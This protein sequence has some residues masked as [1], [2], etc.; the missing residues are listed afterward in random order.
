MSEFKRARGA[1]EKEQRRAAILN[2]A[3]MLFSE[4]Q[5]SLP[6][7][8]QI[9]KQA[10]IAKGTLY[11]Y[12]RSKEEIFLA[13]LEDYHRQ[14]LLNLEQ[15]IENNNDSIQDIVEHSCQYLEQ[16]PLFFRLA[17]L[18]SSIIEQNIDTNILIANK[19]EMAQQLK[20]AAKAISRHF[21]H[22]DNEQGANLIMHSYACLIGLW[23]VSHPSDAIAK[24][25]ESPSLKTLKP[26][27]SLSARQTMLTLWQSTLEQ[28]KS[29]KSG[30]WKKLFS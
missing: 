3:E 21:T 30:I 24:V 22:V 28:K 8:A 27:F 13:L 18:S 19:N 15:G 26:E 5:S 6:T 14:W 23:Q 1:K 16:H 11:L 20:S 17:S 12:F 7:T 25:L 2:A 10:G 29:E 9:G 4:Q